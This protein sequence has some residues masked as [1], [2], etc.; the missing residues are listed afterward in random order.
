MPCANR[1]A[2]S[3]PP[4]KIAVRP[5]SAGCNSLRIDCMALLVYN[6]PMWP[7]DQ[8][9]SHRNTLAQSS[10]SM[11]GRAWQ[12]VA[13]LR[14]CGNPFFALLFAAQALAADSGFLG[15]DSCASS[16]CHGGGGQNQNQNIVWS[17][18]DQHARAPATLTTARSRRLADLLKISDPTKDHR[19]TSC[20]APWQNLTALPA[21]T[22][23]VSEAVSCESCHGPAE[24]YIRSH[25]RKDLNRAE[26]L[27]DGLRDLTILYNRANSCVACHQVVPSELLEAGH[28]ELLFELDGQAAAMPRHWREREGNTHAA[29]WVTGQAA[30]LRE[31]TWQLI[32]EV[33]GGKN[34]DRARSEE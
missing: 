33:K 1:S 25:T 10:F 9:V 17:R 20:H 14:A 31:L 28:P 11:C 24:K 34:S 23:V 3:P 15:K 19:C 18:Q 21:N 30:A 16:S 4:N 13:Q 26:K 29:A 32:D 6:A 5:A 22:S 27:L 12:M 2:R 8:S 7:F